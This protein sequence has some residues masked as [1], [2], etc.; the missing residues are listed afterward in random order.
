MQNTAVP[1]IPAGTL[2]QTPSGRRAVTLD[3]TIAVTNS[4][5]RVVTA[6]NLIKFTDNDEIFPG[7]TGTWE[8]GTLT[9]VENARALRLIDSNGY[10]VV[11]RDVE[12]SEVLAATEKL[13]T[14]D[15]VAHAAQWTALGFPSDAR[16]YRV[17]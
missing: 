6:T 13:L 12:D 2:V 3:N 7:S 9:V 14:V 10:T 5:T 4:Q 17:V 11:V 8:T 1:A 16:S 15:A